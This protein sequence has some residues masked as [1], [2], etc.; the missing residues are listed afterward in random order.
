MMKRIPR[1]YRNR[2]V[3]GRERLAHFDMFFSGAVARVAVRFA[4]FPQ[5]FASLFLC[6]IFICAAQ[7]AKDLFDQAAQALASGDYPA[8]E[9]GF[10][11]VLREEPRHVGA[12]GNLGIIYSRT[13]RADQA[14]AV[15][16][17]AL[18]L[19]PDDKALL[20]NLGL[21]Y[22]KQE[23]HRRALP[24]FER[25]VALDPQNRQARQLLAVCR[26]YTGQL[27]PAIDELEALRAANPRDQ[28]ILFL[29]GFAYLKNHNPE[30]AKKIF[31]NMLE[32]AGP[33]QAQFLLGRASYEAGLFPPAEESFLAAQ[34]L[35]PDLP[36]VHVELGKVYMNQ[37][38]AEDAIR[39]LGLAL[40][41]NAN[42]Q[43]AN[44]FLGSLLVE[45]A[46]YADAIPYLER[47]KE[48]KPDSGAAF[49]H[50]GIAKLRLDRPA[51]AVVLLQRA[52][53]LN[54]DDASAYYVLGQSLKACGRETESRRA[55]LRVK[56]LK[57]G[58][59]AT[60]P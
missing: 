50:L 28:Q 1:P 37:H 27:K 4:R 42:D 26:L 56:E 10:Q 47:A 51:E 18:K 49:C 17:R 33:A 58:S 48:L 25:V 12:L 31:E 36:G 22:L 55:F 21:V 59:D 29:L 15:Y 13:G 9:R 57:T 7:P 34:R 39:E 8:A 6:V 38:R 60:V 30:T 3:T 11:S 5:T 19:S 14:I 20:L 40:K 16:Q 35:D 32:V 46:R 43:E 53:A 45:V 2:A 52:V 41:E 23:S 54:P 24:L 44:Y